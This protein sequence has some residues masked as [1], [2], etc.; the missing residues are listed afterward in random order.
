MGR[1]RDSHTKQ[2]QLILPVFREDPSLGKKYDMSASIHFCSYFLAVAVCYSNTKPVSL[3]TQTCHVEEI[4]ILA[5]DAQNNRH[6]N[7]N[8]ELLLAN[9]F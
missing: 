2:K 5:L 1:V 8:K 7:L 6:I 9:P 3:S 4:T